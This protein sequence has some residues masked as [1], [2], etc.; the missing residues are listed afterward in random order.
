MVENPNLITLYNIYKEQIT[1]FYSPSAIGL[2]E[3]LL[4]IDKHK[5]FVK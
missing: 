5:K 2:Q 4:T 1:N 3:S